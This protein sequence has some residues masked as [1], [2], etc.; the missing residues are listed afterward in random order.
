[1]PPLPQEPYP[2]DA[3][4][5]EPP[6]PPESENGPFHEWHA[7]QK[8]AVHSF[9]HHTYDLQVGSLVPNQEES[10]YVY[11][12]HHQQPSASMPSPPVDPSE[13]LLFGPLCGR[14]Q[15]FPGRIS[16]LFL[17]LPFIH[18]LK[19]TGEFSQLPALGDCCG[20]ERHVIN[21]LHARLSSRLDGTMLERAC[22]V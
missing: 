18:I 8:E 17:H 5:G 21:T 2:A 1:V 10:S 3:F 9:A 22:S 7:F 14:L 11:D 15:S 12:Q 19:G 20:T 6:L 4:P 13:L 16:L